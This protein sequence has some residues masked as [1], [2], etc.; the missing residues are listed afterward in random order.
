MITFIY[1]SFLM[2]CIYACL[3]RSFDHPW[4]DCSLPTSN[5]PI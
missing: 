1:P 2:F 3:K 5:G 4:F